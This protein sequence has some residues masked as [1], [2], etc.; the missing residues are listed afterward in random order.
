M[1]DA[2]YPAPTGTG[3]RGVHHSGTGPGYEAG[4]T[5]RDLARQSGRSFSF[6]CTVLAETGATFR[7]RGGWPHA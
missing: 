2:S 7:P 6:V 5:I 4:V 3:L 1:K